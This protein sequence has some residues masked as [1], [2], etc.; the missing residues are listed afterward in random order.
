LNHYV[1]FTYELNNCG[2]NDVPTIWLTG[3]PGSGKST[4]GKLLLDVLKS[5]NIKTE[6]LDG[7]E[8]RKIISSELGFTK[9]DRDTHLKRVTYISEILNRNGII[10][11]VALISPYR[12]M[13]QY[14]RN[15]IKNFIEVWVKCPLDICKARDPKGLYKKAASGNI[16]ML[17]GIQ[18]PYEYPL[19]PEII[20]ET[21]NESE[22][23][24][25]DKIVKFLMQKNW[26]REYK[27][28]Q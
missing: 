8:L 24:S 2:T 1:D 28:H 10:S 16:G 15:K 12:D 3:L 20:I 5:N 19:N 14:A 26:L 25:L 7:D 27:I 17:T 11:I 9:K 6:L 21:S 4:V 18:D 22:S 13:R 23:E